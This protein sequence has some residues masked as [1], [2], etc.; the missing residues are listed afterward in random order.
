MVGLR[1]GGDLARPEEEIGL[2]DVSPSERRGPYEPLA[3][4]LTA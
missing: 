3:A 4:V 1:D 2:I